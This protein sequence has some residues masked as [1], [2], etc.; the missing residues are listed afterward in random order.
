MA[1][2]QNQFAL[3]ST[4]GLV[5]G[6]Q[7]VVRTVQVSLNQATALV[8]GQAVKIEDVG[9][10]LPQVLA[11]T[12]DHNVPMG[13]VTYNQK[14]ASFSAGMPLEL[15]MSNTIV[16]MTAGAAIA[17]LQP[18]HFNYTTNKVVPLVGAYPQVG[19]AYGKALADGDL[20]QVWVTV[21]TQF[22]DD[23]HL[24]A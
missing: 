3:T 17:W 16:T 13:V 22:V 20:I 4:P 19:I 24:T 1:I 15:A 10:G 21:P 8:P 18:L 5:S 6:N 2:N 11:I 12:E 7:G 9:Q 14:N 23:G